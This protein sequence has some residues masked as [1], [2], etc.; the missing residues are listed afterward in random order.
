MTEVSNQSI[1]SWGQKRRAVN[2]APW[3]ECDPV[4]NAVVAVIE[5]QNAVQRT[6]DAMG[7]ARDDGTFATNAEVDAAFDARS[8]A[9]LDLLA[10]QIAYWRNE[11]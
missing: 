7:E 6:N 8:D 10:A 2:V 3:D 4:A 11:S 1:S 5:A 9:I